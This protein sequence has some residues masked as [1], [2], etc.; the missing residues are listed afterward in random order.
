MAHP[1][2]VVWEES[3]NL[4]HPNSKSVS[5]C[6]LLDMQFGKM[7]YTIEKNAVKQG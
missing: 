7:K 3:A 1:K 6:H 4:G 5:P 2:K